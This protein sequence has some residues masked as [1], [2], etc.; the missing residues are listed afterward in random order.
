MVTSPEIR[1]YPPTPAKK[2]GESKPS[3]PLMDVQSG[4][5]VLAEKEPPKINTDD[6]KTNEEHLSFTPLDTNPLLKNTAEI[7][8]LFEKNQKTAS[9]MFDEL[10]KKYGRKKWNKNDPLYVAW[11]Q[12]T[13]LAPVL[14][15]LLEELKNCDKKLVAIN[16]KDSQTWKKMAIEGGTT[17]PEIKQAAQSMLKQLQTD[18]EQY[19]KARET[20]LEK[21]ASQLT[22]SFLQAGN[23]TVK[24]TMESQLS[25][26][27]Q[28][29]PET[30]LTNILEQMAEKTKVASGG[31][32]NINAHLPK[33]WFNRA[34]DKF[35][36]LLADG[37]KPME[38][39]QIYDTFYKFVDD[40][41]PIINKTVKPSA[42][43]DVREAS[44]SIKFQSL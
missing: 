42:S 30:A 5:A 43:R 13:K 28:T 32:E 11:L 2:I 19:L 9:E 31:E 35:T 36:G 44:P 16:T 15:E 23:G 41:K 24:Q 37:K 4:P 14:Q 18:N 17:R 29:Q 22:G 3:E 1:S 33:N 8:S 34:K 20:A 6:E 21:F 10:Q 12:T 7:S 27:I 25:A 40:Y 26:F 38:A 39:D